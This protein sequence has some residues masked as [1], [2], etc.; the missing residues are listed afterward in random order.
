MDKIALEMVQND[1]NTLLTTNFSTY[2]QPFAL[3]IGPKK[4]FV[5]SFLLLLESEMAWVFRSPDSKAIL[6]GLG[7]SIL[8]VN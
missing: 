8:T 5:R 1:K 2:L 7:N 3:K 6:G 4:M